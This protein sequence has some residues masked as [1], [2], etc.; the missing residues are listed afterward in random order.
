[1][2]HHIADP[3]A[4][5]ANM[6]AS[7]KTGGAILLIEPDFLPVS[8]A[9]PSEVRAFWEGWL[10]WS[11]GCGIDYIGRTL[12]AQLAALDLEDVRGT[13]ETAVYKGGSLW[14]KY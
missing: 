1:M 11:R 3:K 8:A 5:I 2:L 9:E 4:A 10:E 6:A 13:A 14:A 12:P 7:L